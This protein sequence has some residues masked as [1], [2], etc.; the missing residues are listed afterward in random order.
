MILVEYV[1][2]QLIQPLF[3]NDVWNARIPP[4]T[5][6]DTVLRKLLVVLDNFVRIEDQV[7]IRLL[8]IDHRRIGVMVIVERRRDPC[9]GIV[10]KDSFGQEKRGELIRPAP[11]ITLRR[12]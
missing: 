7:Y 11:L 12:G 1:Y 3:L 4:P 9:E 2:S 6:L 8:P 5:I 10:F